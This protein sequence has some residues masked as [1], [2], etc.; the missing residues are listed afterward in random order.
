[1]GWVVNAALPPAMKSGTLC[2]GDSVG[3]SSGPRGCG[4]FRLH[5]DSNPGPS[6]MSTV[7]IR[8]SYPCLPVNEINNTKQLASFQA[9]A[10][11]VYK[12]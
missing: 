9:S 12:A 1:M 5:P 4:K 10:A 8:V 3:P 2:T 11:E 6:N 7:A